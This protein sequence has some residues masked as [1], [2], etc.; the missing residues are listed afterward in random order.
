MDALGEVCRNY[1]VDGIE[2]DFLRGTVYFGPSIELRAFEQKH[3]DMMRR[4]RGI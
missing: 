4:I 3:L 2:L 1:D